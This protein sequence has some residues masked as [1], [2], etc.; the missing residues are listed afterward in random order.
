MGVPVRNRH[1]KAIAAFIT[2]YR[3]TR[4]AFVL[5]TWPF[6]AAADHIRIPAS[7]RIGLDWARHGSPPEKP[8]PA[9]AR[10]TTAAERAPLYAAYAAAR[11]KADE[12]GV[13]REDDAIIQAAVKAY[14][15]EEIARLRH[16]LEVMTHV[17]KGNKRHVAEQT[18]IIQ[19]LEDLIID[20]DRDD[21][22]DDETFTVAEIKAALYAP[23]PRES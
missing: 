16:E 12:L 18:V 22:P 5:T 1:S 7:L 20:T 3:V 21:L 8:R 2:R 23:L 6:I 4:Y 15:T 10:V 14:E 11:A 17:A 13:D 9:P 19:R